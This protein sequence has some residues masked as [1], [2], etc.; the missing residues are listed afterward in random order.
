MKDVA[1]ALACGLRRAGGFATPVARDGAGILAPTGGLDLAWWT[2]GRT[3]TAF[4]ARRPT[5]IALAVSV[6]AAIL[7]ALT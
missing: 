4:Y 6:L 2:I 1:A 7:L 5:R 3:A